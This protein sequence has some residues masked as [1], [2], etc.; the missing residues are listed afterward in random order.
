MTQTLYQIEGYSFKLCE[1]YYTL[2]DYGRLLPGNFD[3]EAAGI[4]SL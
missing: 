4:P 1:K 2:S 3:R